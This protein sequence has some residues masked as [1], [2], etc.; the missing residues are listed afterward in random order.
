MNNK[1]LLQIAYVLVG[2]FIVMIIGGVWLL[3]TTKVWGQEIA[4]SYNEFVA[5]KKKQQYLL[6]V[7]KEMQDQTNDIVR[8]SESIVEREQYVD[9]VENLEKLAGTHNLS[10][11]IETLSNESSGT[12]DDPVLRYNVRG[13]TVGTW[14]DTVSFVADLEMLQQKVKVVELA[15]LRGDD[16]KKSKV[17]VW[18]SVFTISV[19]KYK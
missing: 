5:E 8:V 10:V 13:K 9:F 11:S 15:L 12:E 4:L 16:D 19:L 2:F 6:E 7:Q 1:R 17:P 3:R 14:S 18:N